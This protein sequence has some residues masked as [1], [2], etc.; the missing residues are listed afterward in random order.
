MIDRKIDDQIFLLNMTKSLITSH[1][2]YKL[3]MEQDDI[4]F[5]LEIVLDGINKHKE[6]TNSDILPCILY[7]K[8]L[9]VLDYIKI[10]KNKD[11]IK[12]YVELFD[13]LENIFNSSY[14]EN[15]ESIFN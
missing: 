5:H 6:Q 1:I 4:D 15:N 7:T 10:A 8:M 3:N 12:R 9:F 11:L 14:N 2:F 13:Y